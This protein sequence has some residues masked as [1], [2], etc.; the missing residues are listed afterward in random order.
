MT[1]VA[2][3]RWAARAVTRPTR[4]AAPA[5]AVTAG[6][7]RRPTE[8]V[9]WLMERTV[10]TTLGEHIPRLCVEDVRKL[11]AG[12]NEPTGPELRESNCG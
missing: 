8:G 12:D 4:D 2:C 3:G 5:D 11:S 10:R 9:I 1:A 6:R 7:R